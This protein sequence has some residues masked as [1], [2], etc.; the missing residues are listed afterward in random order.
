MPPQPW[1]RAYKTDHDGEVTAGLIGVPS[2][3]RLDERNSRP[4]W[5][6]L[7]RN[8]FPVPD[9][10]TAFPGCTNQITFKFEPPRRGSSPTGLTADTRSAAWTLADEASS[11]SSIENGKWPQPSNGK[12]SPVTGRSGAPSLNTLTQR[13]QGCMHKHVACSH[14]ALPREDK[15]RRWR[16]GGGG[17]TGFAHVVS[18]RTWTTR[19]NVAGKERYAGVLPGGLGSTRMR[20]AAMMG[21]ILAFVTQT[22]MSRADLTYRATKCLR[23]QKA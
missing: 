18:R 6:E 16:A 22:D 2:Y 8:I 20:P 9:P 17:G 4:V 12:P 23:I 5:A 21:N 7:R 13:I 15:S 1:L 3:Y 11:D 10:G 14:D 19:P